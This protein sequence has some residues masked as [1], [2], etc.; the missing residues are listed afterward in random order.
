MSCCEA[1]QNITAN[2]TF[3]LLALFQHNKVLSNL[4]NRTNMLHRNIRSPS[5]VMLLRVV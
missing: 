4:K 1:K 5:L 3:T 2:S